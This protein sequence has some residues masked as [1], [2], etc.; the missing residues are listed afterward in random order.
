MEGKIK[1]KSWTGEDIAKLKAKYPTADLDALS[2]E[3]DRSARAIACK[4]SKLG[5][6]R[7]PENA[8]I[9]GQKF[10]SFCK[11]W[12]PI[13]EFYQNRHKLNGFEYY[14]K[15]YY[16]TR[17]VKREVSI[18]DK[19]IFEFSKD[20]QREYVAVSE[21]GK[22][23]ENQTIIMINNIEGKL[24]TKCWKWHPLTYFKVSYGDLGDRADSCK[25]CNVAPVKEKSKRGRTKKDDPRVREIDGIVYRT[26]NNCGEEKVQEGNYTLIN[27]EK[28]YYRI[29]CKDC[30][31]KDN[32]K[33]YQDR[34]K[35]IC[36]NI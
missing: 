27:K 23:K 21:S 30:A 29:I 9:E 17:K 16:I 10:C 6:E 4:A 24:C 1:R 34:K 7:V 15:R 28:G 19:S 11:K 20:I 33:K 12:H 14:C 13:G 32:R 18:V 26:C 36:G 8:I 3:M 2:L 31:N 22:K 5:L 35:E 25:D